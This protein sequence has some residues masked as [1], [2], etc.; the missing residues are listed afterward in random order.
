MKEKSESWIGS[1]VAHIYSP[2]LLFV[3]KMT[4]YKSRG[5]HHSIFDEYSTDIDA[6]ITT[7]H[8]VNIGR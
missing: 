1:K 7:M 6:C 5:V 8:N 4:T 3:H 2:K